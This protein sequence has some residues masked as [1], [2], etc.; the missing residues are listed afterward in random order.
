MAWPCQG[1]ALEDR[2]RKAAFQDT[3]GS[4]S[5][6]LPRAREFAEPPGA[7]GSHFREAKI[8]PPSSPGRDGNPQRKDWMGT[9]LGR[10]PVF[11]LHYKHPGACIT[12]C[13]ARGWAEGQG[14]CTREWRDK[15]LLMYFSSPWLRLA[16]PQ[17]WAGTEKTRRPWGQRSQCYSKYRNKPLKHFTLGWP[18][19]KC[20]AT[21]C[22]Q[23]TRAQPTT[24]LH[25]LPA[26]GGATMGGRPQ[27][28]GES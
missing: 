5:R 10:A 14:S 20:G 28:A 27:I 12:P 7:F 1:R 15:T 19:A 16:S 23:D 24:T 6:L 9:T 22:Y 25:R 4:K 18:C 2:V 8:V 26:A 3:Q 11:C 21:W 13:I 17:V